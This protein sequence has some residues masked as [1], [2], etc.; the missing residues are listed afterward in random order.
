MPCSW[1][2]SNELIRFWEVWP[3]YLRHSDLINQFWAVSFGESQTLSPSIHKFLQLYE[4]HMAFF[5]ETDPT[6]LLGSSYS[7]VLT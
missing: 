2:V 3:L 6:A 5:L 1:G 4:N 7:T